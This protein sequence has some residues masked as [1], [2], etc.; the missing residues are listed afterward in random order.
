MRASLRQDIITAA[1]ALFNERGYHQVGMR[2]IAGALGISVGNLTYHFPKKQDIL[3]AIMERNFHV[4]AVREEVTTLGQLQT[5]LDKMLA[6]LEVN[7][8]YFRDPSLYPL[9]PAGSR[10]VEDLYQLLLKALG[11]L[12]AKG[13]FS[14]ALTGERRED[15]I[16]ILMLSHLGWIQQS[17]TFSPVQGMDRPRFLRAHWTLMEPYLTEKGRE[18]F[19]QEILPLF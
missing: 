13:L 17:D 8:F 15:L 19:R 9:N 7:A 5:L 16:R 14:P 4:T 2:D 1:T 18:A 11:A 10:D 12:E 3:Q 6:S